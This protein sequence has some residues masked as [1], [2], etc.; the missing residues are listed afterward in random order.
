MSYDGAPAFTYAICSLIPQQARNYQ[1]L[2]SKQRLIIPQLPSNRVQLHITGKVI[3]SK[4]KKQICE[5]FT[6]PPYMTYIHNWFQWTEACA[7]TID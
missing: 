6:V 2:Y 5:A 4:A 7:D 1:S 3:S